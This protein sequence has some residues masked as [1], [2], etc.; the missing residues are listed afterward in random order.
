MF[1]E[2]SAPSSMV[3]RPKVESLVPCADMVRSLERA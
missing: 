3:N 2:N 1:I